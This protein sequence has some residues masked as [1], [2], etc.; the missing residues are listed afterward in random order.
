MKI[1]IDIDCTPEEAREYMGLPNIAAM[2]EALV[3]EL[4]KRMEDN[5]QSMDAETFMKT[6]C[7]PFMQG[8]G[9][10]FTGGFGQNLNDMQKMFWNNMN[11]GMAGSSSRKNQD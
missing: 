8:M 5:I 2:Q 3:A 10:N 6:W 9:Q 1:K 4:Q 7:Q 11:M